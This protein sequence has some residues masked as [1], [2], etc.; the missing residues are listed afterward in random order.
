MVVLVD[1]YSY[2]YRFQ[3]HYTPLPVVVCAGRPIEPDL[4]KGLTR[5]LI[6]VR[7]GGAISGQGVVGQLTPL[8]RG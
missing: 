4:F 3:E 7:T 8:L 1:A 5:R 2:L 6:T